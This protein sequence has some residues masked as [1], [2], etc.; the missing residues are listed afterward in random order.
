M[1]YILL[2]ILFMFVTPFVKAQDITI[3]QVNAKW[4][5]HNDMQIKGVRGAKIQ[6]ALLGEQSIKF[7]KGI[8]SVP[9]ILIYKDQT[10]VWKKEAGLSF[11][12]I[13][14]KDELQEIVDNYLDQ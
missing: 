6:Y 4:N 2:V 12:L 7:Q 13:L 1:K 11:T 14:S 8:K 10:L 3:L 9:A 5:Q